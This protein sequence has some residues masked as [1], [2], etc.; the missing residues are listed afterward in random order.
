[1]EL[2]GDNDAGAIP[3]ISSHAS[4]LIGSRPRANGVNGR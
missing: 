1:V 2:D 3:T 4:R